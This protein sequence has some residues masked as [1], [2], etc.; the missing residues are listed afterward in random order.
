MSKNLYYDDVKIIK[1]GLS[2]RLKSIFIL[3]LVVLT[4]G[5]VIMASVYLSRALSVGNIASALVFGGTEINIKKHEMYMVTLGEYNSLEE[6]NNVGLG[7]TVQGASGYVW[8]ENNKY[9]VV[10]NI[11][12]NREDAEKVKTNLSSSKYDVKIFTI[13]F[14]KIKLKFDYEN[15]EVLKIREGINFLDSTYDTFYD[16]SIKFDKGQLNNF[17][18]SS[19]LSSLRGECK[20]KITAVQAVMSKYKNT[21]LQPLIDSLLRVDEILNVTM[22]KTI[23]NSSTNYSLK[24]AISEIVNIKYDLYNNL[25]K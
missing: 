3:F 21:G 17:A 19:G 2:K 18:I 4:I 14:P 12:K 25:Q 1:K 5:G 7:S 8:T 6:A 15:S 11:Y 20:V 23:D 22:L 9:M 16:Y 10:G 13:T 24:N